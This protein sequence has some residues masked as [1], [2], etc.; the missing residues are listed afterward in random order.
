MVFQLQEGLMHQE[1]LALACLP[2]NLLRRNGLAMCA[3]PGQ[4][5]A[6]QSLHFMEV[7]VFGAVSPMP[8]LQKYMYWTWVTV[9]CKM[10]GLDPQSASS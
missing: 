9:D 3:L 6:S 5:L 7:V 2:G 8:G 10:C 4:S 1:G